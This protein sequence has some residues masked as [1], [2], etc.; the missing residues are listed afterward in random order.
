VF[1]ANGV[2]ATILVEVFPPQWAPIILVVL[3]I[4][5]AVVE[6]RRGLVRRL[7]SA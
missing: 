1:L 4:V 7:W 6:W 3:E 5:A 2:V